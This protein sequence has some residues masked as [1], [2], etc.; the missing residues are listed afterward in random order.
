MENI[1]NWEELFKN[2][3]VSIISDF[4]EK[5]EMKPLLSIFLLS[6]FG[7]KYNQLKIMVQPASYI[8]INENEKASSILN[9]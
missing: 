6:I 7:G 5:G 9:K 4:F 8:S 1:I 2:N 3:Q